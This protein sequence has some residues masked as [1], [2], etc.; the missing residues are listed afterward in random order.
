LQPSVTS[1][2]SGRIV[3]HRTAVAVDFDHQLSSRTIEV[4]RIGAQR[5]LLAELQA[6]RTLSKD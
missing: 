3:A 1:P 4:E 2:V 5:M 6:V